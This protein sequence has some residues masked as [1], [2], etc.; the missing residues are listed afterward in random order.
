M[1]ILERAMAK[2][3]APSEFTSSLLLNQLRQKLGLAMEVK[4]CRSHV[5]FPMC[6]TSWVS[7]PLAAQDLDVGS[8]GL[9]RLGTSRVAA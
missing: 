9:W 4:F 1:S 8:S 5:S 3:L 2:H 6:S 7:S